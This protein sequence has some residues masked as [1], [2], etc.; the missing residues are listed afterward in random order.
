MNS[1][2]LQEMFIYIATSKLFQKDNAYKIGLTTNPKSRLS[3]YLTGCP[4]ELPISA[5]LEFIKIFRVK[6][7]CYDDLRDYE[8]IIHNRFISNRLFRVV[9]GDSEWFKFSFEE[10]EKVIE[11]IRKQEWFSCEILLDSIKIVDSPKKKQLKPY[12]TNPKIIKKLEKRLEV[13]NKLQD[14][15]IEK[16]IDFINSSS[17]ASYLIAPCGFG[18]TIVAVKSICGLEKVVICCPSNHI[19]R[20]WRD[21]IIHYNV[22]S[23]SDILLIGELG[24]TNKTKISN[25]TKHNTF[26]IITTYYSCSLL[27]DLIDSDIQLVINDEAHHLSG[28]V[29]SDTEEEGDGITRKLMMKAVELGIKRLSLTY[30][31]K[32]IQS[33]DKET[34]VISMEDTKIFGDELANISLRTLIDK[35]VLPDYKIWNLTDESCV[36]TG[37]RAK[38]EYITNIWDSKEYYRGSERYTLHHLIIFAYTIEDS[39]EIEGYLRENLDSSSNTE[40][41]R[42][43]GGNKGNFKSIEKFRK[44]ERAIIVNCKVLNEGVDIPEANSVCIIY[45]KY[46]KI[47]IT[48]M[49]LRAGR[50]CENKNVFHILFPITREEDLGGMEEVLVSLASIDETLRDEL[51][52]ISKNLGETEEEKRERLSGLD[53]IMPEHIMVD[54]IDGYDTE[55]LQKSF[56][57]A[58]SKI[59]AFRERNMIQ[60]ICLKENIKTSLE[61]NSFR[62]KNSNLLEDPRN[63]NE[64][65]FD[66]LN[67]KVKKIDIREFVNEICVKNNIRDAVDYIRYIRD[68]SDD[69]ISIQ[70]I[71]D[72]YFGLEDVNFNKILEKYTIKKKGLG[73]R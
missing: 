13:L 33:N 51:V 23:S 53:D 38:V 30:T 42:V 14:P 31:P 56:S 54:C 55:K 63:K 6:A 60:A 24:T 62:E 68:L 22:F 43:E 4:P 28:V 44:A 12:I 72:G 1:E 47:E 32:I 25:F 34:K 19:V 65:W 70:N 20:Q 18:K 27:Y 10:L 7:S 11:F 58:C 9:F 41:F 49:L 67:P 59:R 15:I 35:G 61:Y 16:T 36:A 26:C 29:A 66:F 17:D 45:P 8:E 73:R 5:D 50:W 48:Q 64:T 57:V 69:I 40:I 39:K 21:S 2:K 37:L 46:S 52:Y 71:T 3:Q